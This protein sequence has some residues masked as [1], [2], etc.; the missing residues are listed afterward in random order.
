M[1]AESI[2]PFYGL[3]R[4]GVKDKTPT[5]RMRLSGGQPAIP[6]IAYT[7]R[8]L[9]GAVVLVAAAMGVLSGIDPAQRAVLLNP[10]VALKHD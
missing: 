8:W 4:G 6:D 7:R 1:P 5:D 10:V 9:P 3:G 2:G